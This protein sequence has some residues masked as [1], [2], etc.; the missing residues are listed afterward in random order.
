MTVGASIAGFPEAAIREMMNTMSDHDR[1]L[2]L[3]LI[4]R[5][6]R[7]LL[8]D[9]GSPREDMNVLTAIVRRLDATLTVLLA[10]AAVACK[11]QIV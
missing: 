11:C 1:Q 9:V 7:Q 10:E 2:D 3:S 6:M 4:A 5:H 8:S